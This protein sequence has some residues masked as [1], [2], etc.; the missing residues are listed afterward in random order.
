MTMTRVTKLVVCVLHTYVYIIIPRNTYLCVVD[1]IT[2][3]FTPLLFSR[4]RSAGWR[5]PTSHLHYVLLCSV[6]EYDSQTPDKPN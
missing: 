6:M 5:L 3:I 1:F 4:P 2:N